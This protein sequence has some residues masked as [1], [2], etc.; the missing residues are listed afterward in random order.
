MYTPHN[1]MRLEEAY[2]VAPSVKTKLVKMGNSRG[3]RISKPVIEQLRLGSE[4]QVEIHADCLVIRPS[5][6]PRAGW[7]DALMQQPTREPELAFDDGI[8]LTEWEN[9]EWEW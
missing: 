3:I 5:A 2:S 1:C 9:T 4:V 7:E 8:A 6:H